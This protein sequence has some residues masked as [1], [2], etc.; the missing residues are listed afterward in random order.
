[1]ANIAHI[2]K[3]A[4][5]GAFFDFGG[6]IG[7]EESVVTASGPRAPYGI[8]NPALTWGSGSQSAGVVGTVAQTVRVTGG[9][10]S[11]ER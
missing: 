9:R 3:T 2:G 7:A 8:R 4:G 6:T 5:R 11:N 1:M 10:S